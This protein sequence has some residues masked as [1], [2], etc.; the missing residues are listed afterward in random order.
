MQTAVLVNRLLCAHDG[1]MELE[2]LYGQISGLNLN[3]DV[4][5]VL[6]DKDMF[7]TSGD[8][9]KILVAKTKLRLCRVKDCEG[10]SNLHL[11]K[12]HLFG[13]CPYIKERGCHFHHDLHSEHNISVLHQHNLLDMDRSE[14]CVILLQND[15]ALLPQV[16]FT[17]NNGCGEY[18]NCPDKEVCNRLH[19]CENYIRGT[20]EGTTECSRSHDFYEP[21]PMKTLQ[22]KGVPSQLMGSMLSA[23]RNKLT[24]QDAN[25]VINS[26]TAINVP[27]KCEICLFHIKHY[28]KQGIRCPKV[29]FQ[30]PYKWEGRDGKSWKVLPDNEEVERAF[31]DP[32]KSYS[33]GGFPVHFDAMSNDSGEV[34]RLS[35]PSSVLKPS[36]IFTTTWV[37]YWE[38]G[39]GN[40]IQYGSQGTHHTSSITSEDLERSYQEDHSAT[41][42]FTAG[43]QFYELNMADFMQYNRQ[44]GTKRSVRRRPVFLSAPD[45]TKIKESYKESRGNF[46][47]LKALP[48][49]WDKTNMPESGFK[50][51]L[52]NSTT[53][54][55][56]KIAD[57]FHQTM[58]ESNVKSIERVQNR[59][60]WEIYQW[61]AD[62][63]RKRTSG[64][65]NE[66]LLFHGTES[67]HTDAI[68]Q[69][70][71]DWRICGVHGTAYGKGSYFARDAKYSHSYTDKSGTCCMFVCRVLVGKYTT[72]HSSYL[73]PPL[74]DGEHNIFYDSC[75][76]DINNP[77]IFVIFEKHQ[78]YPEF[79]IQYDRVENVTAQVLPSEF[80]SI[81]LVRSDDL[82]L[83]NQL[84]TNVSSPVTISEQIV[85]PMIPT[86]TAFTSPQFVQIVHQHVVTP[87]YFTHA[88]KKSAHQTTFTHHSK[89]ASVKQT[90]K[91]KVSRPQNQQ[92]SNDRRTSPLSAPTHSSSDSRT[93]VV[94]SNDTKKQS[95]SLN[96]SAATK[97]S[98]PSSAVLSTG[99]KSS[100]SGTTKNEQAESKVTSSA[101]RLT[102]VTSSSKL[103]TGTK[104]S[105][106]VKTQKTK[107]ETSKKTRTASSASLS[108]H[109]NATKSV[110]SD[111]VKT[112]K[113]SSSRPK[114]SNA[115]QKSRGGK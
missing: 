96:K 26:T 65:E 68:C 88:N 79:L 35:T 114:T 109:T 50:R 40:W 6:N 83:P 30:L 9:S 105:V 59:D 52:I 51:V 29:H 10:C 53:N 39:N 12:L 108:S 84:S 46:R 17:Y 49:H 76:N 11:C 27:E 2:G 45:V 61:Q 55:Y 69:Q 102:T 48:S 100:K 80:T 75:V 15:T 13:E 64:K 103:S 82:P 47:N 104:T 112:T 36:F 54:E 86:L 62:V 19:V 92:T 94:S 25:R 24:I 4:E 20:C 21:H 34:R 14:L 58:T 57:L 90:T 66:R 23:Y 63:I 91:K 72:G 89:S 93:S 107:Q 73:R 115:S 1:R 78:V 41:V 5:T 32:T 113:P 106:L 77:S 44:T 43:Q 87:H 67:K 16:C 3:D 31:C 70:N 28:C 38:N 56:K 97:S 60:L 22:A 110:R 111:S 18:G 95:S 71:F 33:D 99:G 81:S 7:V 74:K 85:K 42:E 8:E 37:W 98:A 101:S